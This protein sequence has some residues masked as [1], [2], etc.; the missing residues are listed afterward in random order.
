MAMFDTLDGL[1]EQ[2]LM[3]VRAAG[4]VYDAAQAASRKRHVS[5][6]IV[7]DTLD[8]RAAAA[9]AAASHVGPEEAAAAA[10]MACPYHT[11]VLTDTHRAVPILFGRSRMAVE[12]RPRTRPGS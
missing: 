10:V 9:E 6:P 3:A 8:A 12:V 1:S 7:L 11:T 5:G 2:F 4:E